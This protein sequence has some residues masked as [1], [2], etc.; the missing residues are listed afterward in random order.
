MAILNKKPKIEPKYGMN[1]IKPETKPITTP[2]YTLI[3]Y[4]PTA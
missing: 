2:S 1:E 4:S 3:K